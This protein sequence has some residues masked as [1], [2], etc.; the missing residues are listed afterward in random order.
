MARYRVSLLVRPV[1]SCPP[2]NRRD[3]LPA[4][5]VVR[6]P[7]AREAACELARP[8]LDAGLVVDWTAR[9]AG[10]RRRGRRRCGQFVPGDGDDGTAGVREPRRPYSPAGD[11]LAAIDIPAA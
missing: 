1:S 8:Y 5:R 7:C 6:A 3:A 11:A 4:R 2:L 10:L 9:R